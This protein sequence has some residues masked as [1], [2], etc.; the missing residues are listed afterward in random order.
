[1][2]RSFIEA[3]YDPVESPYL[4]ACMA[5]DGGIE[6][7]RRYLEFLDE[8]RDDRSEVVRLYLQL[9][10]EPDEDDAP[11]PPPSEL[12][13]RLRARLAH[14]DGAWWRAVA[15]APE[16][17]SCGGAGRDATR[18]VRFRFRCPN[19]WDT[20][21]PTAHKDRRFC[22]TCGEHVHWADSLV[23]A[24]ALARQGACI[25]VPPALASAKAQ[26]LTASVTG[27][28]DWRQR[29]ATRIFGDNP[30]E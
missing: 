16:I 2:A 8:Q 28:P 4:L 27:R 6:A 30:D 13:A 24:E 14:V 17:F 7:R 18:H 3:L 1:M 23:R 12:R 19:N 21:E 10:L 25:S 9:V 20:L 22:V 26:E 15:E 5:R 29:W 11:L